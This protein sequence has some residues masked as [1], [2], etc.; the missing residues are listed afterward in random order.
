MGR[1]V[2]LFKD[3]SDLARNLCFLVLQNAMTSW[4]VSMSSCFNEI[5]SSN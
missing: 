3:A 5:S 4:K 2:F 1:L